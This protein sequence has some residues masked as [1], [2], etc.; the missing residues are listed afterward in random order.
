[1]VGHYWLR[2]PEL[3]PDA[4]IAA[5]VKA[6][7][8]REEVARAFDKAAGIGAGQGAADL[9]HGLAPWR[10]WATDSTASMIA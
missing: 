1:M 6:A 2:A 7:I 3:A 10:F 8:E 4:K 9:G 5:E